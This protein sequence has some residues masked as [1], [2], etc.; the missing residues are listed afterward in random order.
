MLDEFV[1][2]WKVSGEGSKA[3]A[4]EISDIQETWEDLGLLLSL[5]F[6]LQFYLF[7]F[8]FC[9]HDSS[10]FLS[11]LKKS[12]LFGG[13]YPIQPGDSIVG[14]PIGQ[15]TPINQNQDQHTTETLGATT[16]N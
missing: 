5:S 4:P 13:A 7:L 12:L 11:T 2:G 8:P 15:T 16:P 6:L 10:C 3:R 1:E 14:E 9:G